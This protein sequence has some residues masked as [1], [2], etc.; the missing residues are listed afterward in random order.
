M[1]GRLLLRFAFCGGRG[2]K[3]LDE[4]HVGAR[5]FMHG[6]SRLVREAQNQAPQSAGPSFDGSVTHGAILR[7][8]GQSVRARA[9]KS[10]ARLNAA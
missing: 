9:R 10:E 8:K 2:G 7:C 1:P 5:F 6:M 4:G 3:C